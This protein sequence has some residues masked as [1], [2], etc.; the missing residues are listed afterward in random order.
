MDAQASESLN[1]SIWL[2]DLSFCLRAVLAQMCSVSPQQQSQF[3][4]TGKLPLQLGGSSL[5]PLSDSLT[6]IPIQKGNGPFLKGLLFCGK[7][8]ALQILGRWL[9]LWTRSLE[10]RGNFDMTFLFLSCVP[11]FFFEK[12]KENI[13][14][15]H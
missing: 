10:G 5:F 9:Q 3:G 14:R 8:N 15:K 4:L 12:E 6:Q 2:P 13:N 11:L 7:R 1:E